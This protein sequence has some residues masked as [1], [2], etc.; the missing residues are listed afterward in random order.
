LSSIYAK[1]GVNFLVLRNKDF[2]YVFLGDFHRKVLCNTNSRGVKWM[3]RG[4]K[5]RRDLGE[6]KLFPFKPRILK[7]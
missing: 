4:Q 7:F 3:M 1:F 6:A 2:N 5:G